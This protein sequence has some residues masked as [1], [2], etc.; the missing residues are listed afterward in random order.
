MRPAA[1]FVSAAAL[2]ASPPAAQGGRDARPEV[3]PYTEG[4]PAAMDRAG[5]RGFG[6]F[7][8]AEDHTT[9][10]IEETLGGVPLLWV[11]TEHFKIGSSLD[12]FVLSGDSEERKL[13]R[14]ELGRLRKKLGGLKSSTRTLDPW[15]RLHLCAQRL[16]DLYGSFL[17]VFQLEEDEFIDPMMGT[18]PYLGLQDKFC[19]LLVEKKSSLARYTATYCD[20]PVESSYRFHFPTTDTMFFGMAWETLTGTYQNELAFLYAVTF[21]VVANLSNACRGYTHSGPVWWSVGIGRWFARRVDERWMLY[22]GGGETAIRTEGDADWEP[23]VRALVG[24]EYFPTTSEM[25]AWKDPSALKF[26]DHMIVWSRVDYLMSRDDGTA[27]K[28]LLALNEPIA[29]DPIRPREEV[30]QDQFLSA[31]Q[32]ATGLD[33]EAFDEAWCAY[34]KKGYRKR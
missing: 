15:L 10:R 24:H 2:L 28:F 32:F 16:E 31:L 13:V 3:D 22:I 11:E 12:E 23:R 20:R 14:K 29:W 5:Y 26:A 21:Q 18:G 27:R 30:I 8:W 33:P 25:F 7:L 19:V 1:A 17:E 9:E 6:P 4:E 34:V